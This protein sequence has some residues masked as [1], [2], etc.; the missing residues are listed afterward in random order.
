MRAFRSFGLLRESWLGMIGVGI[1]V[2]WVLI[3]LLAPLIA[4]FP[5]NATL[6]P[7][8]MPGAEYAEGG[9]FWLGAD[10]IGRDILSRIMWGSR[11]VLIFA[12]LATLSAYVVGIL[13]G[14][15]AGYLSSTAD[16]VLSAISD[17]ILSFP[18]LVLYILVIITI[19]ASGLNIVIAVTFG[20]ALGKPWR[21]RPRLFVAVCTI[22]FLVSLGGILSPYRGQ[23]DLA[24]DAART[25][26][27]QDL[28]EKKISENELADRV[29]VHPI[30][31]PIHTHWIY[32]WLS[33]SG[34]LERGGSANTTEPLFGIDVEVAEF[35]AVADVIADQGEDRGFRHWWMLY[36]ALPWWFVL[37]WIA[38]TAGALIWSMRQI[39]ETGS[40][41]GAKEP[42]E[43]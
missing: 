32:A 18:V 13:L 8:A 25:H 23:Q 35:L 10:H 15:A 16:D 3:A 20:L 30:Y 22:G 41:S 4:P 43:P 27:A 7:F 24:F 19:G 34:R 38:A 21:R 1:I 14:L 6:Q 5:P 37:A 28:A 2:F 29:N 36:A 11:A 42:M 12:P 39:F 26:Y 40:S 33:A 31:S 17:Y 9:T